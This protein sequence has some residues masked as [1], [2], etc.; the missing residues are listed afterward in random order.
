[1]IPP[2]RIRIW[3]PRKAVKASPNTTIPWSAPPPCWSPRMRTPTQSPW[4]IMV[5]FPKTGA[6]RSK[7]SSNAANCVAWSPHRALNSA[8]TWVQWIWSSRS[9]RHCPYPR[10]CSG[11]G[12]PTTRSGESRM[13]CSTQS[14]ENKS[15]ARPQA[16]NAC[17]PETSK[18]WL[19]TPAGMRCPTHSSPFGQAYGR[20]AHP[21]LRPL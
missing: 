10:D 6:N 19:W 20:T 9:H 5:P 15:S 2:S 8:S 18:H 17:A 11:W 21:A 14:P 13:R 16:S 1:M 7:N 4:R 3:A 12:A